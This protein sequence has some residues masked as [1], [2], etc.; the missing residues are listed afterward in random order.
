MDETIRKP[1]LAT[2]PQ[3]TAA[4]QDMSSTIRVDSPQRTS[5]SPANNET[6]VRPGTS[7]VYM[8]TDAST[9]FVLK[10][11]PYHC[12]RCISDNSGEAQV[13]LVANNEGEKVLKIYY[14]N[15]TINH[16]IV[17]FRGCIYRSTSLG[18]TM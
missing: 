18:S 12:V 17:H 4:P 14:P 3:Q 16:I 5:A 13:F 7:A 1:D 6:T 2:N 8:E 11:R 15:F 9:D 10:G